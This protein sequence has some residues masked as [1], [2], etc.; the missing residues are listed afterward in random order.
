MIQINLNKAKTIAHDI[1]RN[2]R[3]KEFA[4]L[5]ELIMK[6][7]PGTDLSAVEAQRQATRD[8]YAAIQTEIDNAVGVDDLKLIVQ[9]MSEGGQA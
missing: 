5:D 4:P 7:I 8:K 6:Q 3:S 1:R 9:S 2:A